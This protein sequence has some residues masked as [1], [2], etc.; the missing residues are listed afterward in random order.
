MPPGVPVARLKDAR[1]TQGMAEWVLLNVLRFH[2]QD[3][4]YRALQAARRWEELPAPPDT[5]ARRAIFG[6]CWCKNAGT[7]A[8]TCSEPGFIEKIKGPIPEYYYF[9]GM[10]LAFWGEVGSVFEKITWSAELKDLFAALRDAAW[11]L[12]REGLPDGPLTAP[13]T[14]YFAALDLA[15]LAVRLALDGQDVGQGEQPG[16]RDIVRG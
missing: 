15:I 3:L 1:L 6:E 7:T 14:T 2:R 13:G 11:A 8:R 12:V 5:A 16:L 10:C 9:K 4:E